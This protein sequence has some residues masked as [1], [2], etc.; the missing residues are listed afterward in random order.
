MKP[1]FEHIFMNLATDLAQRSHCV[2]AQVGAVLAKD[3]RIISIGYNGPPAGTHNCDEEWPG[4][5]CARDSKGSCSL[6]LHAEENAILY[7]VKNGANLE[8]ATLYTTLSPCL[9]C[10]R[11]IF[12]AGIK[13]VYFDK[14]YAQYKGLTSDEGVDF[15]N[16]F[17]VNAVQF[18]GEGRET[19][20]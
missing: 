7:A 8:G 3:T 12:S 17:G 4:Q 10:A 5:G 13:H 15:L 1:S 16:R 6:A 18:T 19:G 2:K 20:G 14:S 9:P 11:L